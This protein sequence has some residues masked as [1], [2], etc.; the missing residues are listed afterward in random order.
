MWVSTDHNDIEEVAKAW[1]ARVHRRS[2]DVSKDSSTSLETIKEF[3]K[4]NK[5]MQITVDY[6]L[7]LGSPSIFNNNRQLLK[8]HRSIPPGAE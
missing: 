5:G 1:G 8:Q 7:G 2:P 4:D 3:V 6:P